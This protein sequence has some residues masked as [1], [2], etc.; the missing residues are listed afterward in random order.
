MSDHASFDTHL[1]YVECLAELALGATL[2]SSKNLQG[3][4]VPQAASKS[5]LIGLTRRSLADEKSIV[6]QDPEYSFASTSWLP[7]KGYYLVFNQLLTIDYLLDPKPN[8]FGLTHSTCMERFT[9]RL[10]RGDLTFNEPLLNQ[11]F[12][13]SIFQPQD[14]SGANLSR[15]IS[16]ERRFRMAMAKVA[17]YKE[18]EWKRKKK[19][20]S[21]RAKADKEL[22]D[23]FRNGFLL[24]VFE[25]PYY[26]RIRANYRDFAFI[27]GVSPRDTARYFNAYHQ[28]IMSL[29]RA[30]ETL[31]RELLKARQA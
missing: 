8:S 2:K 4:A 3:K 10:A 11:V 17:D 30:L 24:S 12:D 18:D 5:N 31:R 26:M 29:D 27:D 9:K 25:F 7:V 6:D 20:D 15:R 14:L 22:R 23:Q 19:I 1:N 21:Y 28:F 13:G 16:P